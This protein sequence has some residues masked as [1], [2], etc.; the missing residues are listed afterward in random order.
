MFL[1]ARLTS[2]EAVA[3]TAS[4]AK[5][6]HLLSGDVLNSASGLG[7]GGEILV[8]NDHTTTGLVIGGNITMNAGSMTGKINN[9]ADVVRYIK[10]QFDAG[11]MQVNFDKQSKLIQ[12]LTKIGIY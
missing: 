1:V 5:D 6:N 7:I 11:K 8:N 2:Q 9:D 10:D 12:K 3:G 4:D